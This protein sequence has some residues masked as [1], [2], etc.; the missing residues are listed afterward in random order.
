VAGAVLLA[1]AGVGFVCG[2]WNV[3]LLPRLSG[4]SLI[5]RLGRPGAVPPP[6][7]VRGRP[8]AGADEAARAGSAP[9][10]APGRGGRHRAR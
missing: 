4:M 9:A 2:V 6:G 1:L 3:W 7:A 5:A 8:A 10:A